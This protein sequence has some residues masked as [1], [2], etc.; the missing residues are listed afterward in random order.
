MPTP[1]PNMNLQKP[2]IGGDSGLWG[3]L[4]N[5]NMDAI[6]TLAV[7]PFTTPSVS[8]NSAYDST[9]AV[10][11]EYCTGGSAGITRTLPTAIGHGGK[12]FFYKKVDTGVGVV[13]VATTT[14]QTIDTFAAPYVISNLNQYVVV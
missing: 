1:T 10:V 11:Y 9:R 13:N 5:Q 8:G 14:S 12:V 3:V 6:D 7:F 2:T 4:L